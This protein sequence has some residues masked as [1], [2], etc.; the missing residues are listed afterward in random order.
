MN[1]FKIN[2]KC[3]KLTFIIIKF[4]KITVIK[5]Q[6]YYLELQI[7]QNIIYSTYKDHS[8]TDSEEK[9]ELLYKHGIIITASN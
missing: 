7:L 5:L 8:A 9:K 1:I 4:Y 6:S 3:Y 2:F